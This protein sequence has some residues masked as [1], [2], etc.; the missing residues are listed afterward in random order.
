MLKAT[1]D[2]VQCSKLDSGCWEAAMCKR[3]QRCSLTT[4]ELLSSSDP[5]LSYIA[6]VPDHVL[7]ESGH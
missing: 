1:S 6:A 4:W 2:A 3:A 5:C 7:C